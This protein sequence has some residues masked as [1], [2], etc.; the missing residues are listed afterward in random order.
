M[1]FRATIDSLPTFSRMRALCVNSILLAQLCLPQESSNQSRNSRRGVSSSS[2]R[3]RYMSF[4]TMISMKAESKCGRKYSLYCYLS[5]PLLTSYCGLR[6]IKVA[7]L[8]TD[9]RIQSNANNEIT[10]NIATEPLLAVL[11]GSSSSNASVEHSEMVMKLAKKDD[12]AMLQF[13]VRTTT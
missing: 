11:R 5:P 3:L 9:Y 10:M 8:F 4:V 13:E 1:R 7:S 2:L 12:R 6:Q